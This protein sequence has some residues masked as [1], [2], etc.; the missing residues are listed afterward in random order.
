TINHIPNIE[1]ENIYRPF[2]DKI[3]STV[4]NNL[5]LSDSSSINHFQEFSQLIHCLG[6]LCQSFICYIDT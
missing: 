6:P 5:I 1:N 3:R 2:L 4:S